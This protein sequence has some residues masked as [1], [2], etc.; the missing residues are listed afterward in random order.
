M[1]ASLLWRLSPLGLVT[2]TKWREI[3][4]LTVSTVLSILSAE[5]SFCHFR[6]RQRRSLI[7]II[8]KIR[9]KDKYN[10]NTIDR[11]IDLIANPY[12]KYAYIFI[13]FKIRRK[14]KINYAFFEG[15]IQSYAQFQREKFKDS[16]SLFDP[17]K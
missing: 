13:Y 1:L 11:S 2:G 17:R 15:C 4:A 12:V 9:N 16:Q 14:D 6:L 7:I 5:Q 3:S 8:S 10:I